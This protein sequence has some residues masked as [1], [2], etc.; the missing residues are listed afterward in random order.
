MD[1]AVSREALAV[2]AAQRGD[3]A[4]WRALVAEH[5]P[6]V[7]AAC[8]RLDADPDDAY[9][10]IWEKV[11]AAIH[12]FDPSGPRPLPSWVMTI[13]HRA[14]VDRH[15][16]R[17]V[18]GVVIP[19][20]EPPDAPAPAEDPGD[21]IDRAR[22]RTRLE[23]ALSRLPEPQRRVV[24]MHHVHGLDLPAIAEAEGTAIGTLKSRLHRGR[25]RLQALL[26][27]DTP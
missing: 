7:Y 11:I 16:R 2:R 12:R 21:T 8:R 23:E 19:F 9:Q 13:A 6:F 22:L 24:V 18:R 1:V 20:A 3:A 27:R 5:G 25:A 15:R 14:L 17:S 26:T 10:V 4:A